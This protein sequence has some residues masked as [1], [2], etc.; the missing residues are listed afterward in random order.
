MGISTLNNLSTQELVLLNGTGSTIA[1]GDLV[2]N[3]ESGGISVANPALSIAQNNTTSANIV[4]ISAVGTLSTTSRFSNVSAYSQ[5]GDQLSDGTLVFAH[6]GDG[7]SQNNNVRLS[8]RTLTGG[9]PFSTVSV[10]TA[11]SVQNLTVRR[12][13]SAGAVILWTLNTGAFSYAIYNNSATQV[14]AP[15]QILASMPSS[16]ALNEGWDVGVL[17]NSNFVVAYR[18]PTSN[19]LAFSIYDT[20]GT[21]VGTE[22]IVEAA[23]SASVIKVL[24]QSGGGFIVYYYRSTAT[25]AWKFARYN[26]SGALQGS[27]TTVFTGTQTLNRSNLSQIATELNN[28]NIVLV[29]PVS[30]AYPRFSIYSSTGS[31][32]KGETL[33]HSDSNLENTGRTAQ[34]IPPGITKTS[35][36]FTVVS[37]GTTNG[38]TQ[39][40][41]DNIGG[42][43]RA[44]FAR[45]LS[46]F[47]VTN[48]N[49]GN[50][51][52]NLIDLGGAGVLAIHRNEMNGCT[53]NYYSGAFKFSLLGTEA[54]SSVL[55]LSNGGASNITGLFHFLCADGSVALGYGDNNAASA[56]YGTY[57]VQRKSIIGVAQEPIAANATGRIAT[58]GTYTINQNFSSGGNFDVRTAAIPGGRGTVVGSS[59]VLNGVTV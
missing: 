47:Q 11:S 44:G 16:N 54:A 21:I 56:L 9:V 49:G 17:T 53:S 40:V 41:Y 45:G 27:V 43:L 22:V 7:S 48:G 58:V 15:T 4:A 32:V 20:T 14:K 30:T 35:S 51:A 10:A 34:N 26:A 39:T 5:A 6:T 42:V 36:G 8:Y 1:A 18:K 55:T 13:G 28:G 3:T 29:Y 59:V 23:S 52:I 31:L 12:I 57:S 33:L 46:G 19:D 24:P 25:N 2:T 50:G 38:F 37:I